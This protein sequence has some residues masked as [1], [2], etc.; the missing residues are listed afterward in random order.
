MEDLSAA[1]D[2]RVAMNYTQSVGV[3]SV[4]CEG[5]DEVTH[6]HSNT[7]RCTHSHAHTHT[8]TVPTRRLAPDAWDLTATLSPILC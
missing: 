4:W 1:Q 5:R 3:V 2:S 8:H 6:S 7:Q